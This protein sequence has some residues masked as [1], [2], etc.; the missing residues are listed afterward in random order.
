[1]STGTSLPADFSPLP[2]VL[3][4]HMGKAF[5]E[6]SLKVAGDLIGPAGSD[7]PIWLANEPS[8]SQGGQYIDA[9]F[10][11]RM[12]ALVR[13]DITSVAALTAQKVE[14]GNNQGVLLNRRSELMQFADASWIRNATREQ[15]SA[16]LGRQ[17][18]ELVL[19]DLLSTCI[20]A[21]RGMIEAVTAAA[22]THSVWVASGTKVNLSPTVIG[23]GRAKMGDAYA[24][25]THMLVHSESLDDLRNDAVGRGYDSVGGAT[26]QGSNDRN[27]YGIKHALRDDANLAAADA[28]YD[29]RYTLLLGRGAL[30]FKFERPYAVE[31]DRKLDLENKATQWRA[32][33]D[34]WLRSDHMGYNAGAGGA[35]PSNT[36]LATSANWTPGY[37]NHKE[38]PA[39]ELEH[40][41]TA[42]S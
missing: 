37:E 36:A 23:G 42:A 35:N 4:P 18:G 28:G 9:P 5:V 38:F 10:F 40:N 2:Q 12:P 39:V 11:K 6:R 33:G 15:I 21:L 25:L 30:M 7:S 14:G 24:A 26:L 41:A 19:D 16:E 31:T 3:L 13:R 22:H 32:D 34:L 27:S 29:K 17:L 1:M 20:A 8:F